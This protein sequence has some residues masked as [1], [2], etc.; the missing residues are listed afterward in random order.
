MRLS[1]CLAALCL[2]LGGL[3]CRASE[4]TGGGAAIDASALGAPDFR[5]PVLAVEETP[6]RFL[7]Q[8]R[9]EG[10]NS[11][12][13]WFGFREDTRI[14]RPS[15]AR[16]AAADIRPGAILSVW[17]SHPILESDPAQGVADTIV[18]EGAR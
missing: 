18:V 4:T 14:R 15:G 11:G 1:T 8:Y 16:V 9:A 6:R 7:I 5:G 12:R 3:G 17:T 2:V 13:I 10:V